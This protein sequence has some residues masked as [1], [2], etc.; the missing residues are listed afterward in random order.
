MGI[1]KIED[2]IDLREA[3]KKKAAELKMKDMQARASV[4]SFT[5]DRLRDVAKKHGILLALT[6]ELR[7]EVKELQK[8]YNIPSS[9]IITEQITEHNVL[10]KFSKIDHQKL[11]MLAYQRVLMSKEETGG[12]IPLSE[13]FELVNTGIL[14]GNIEVKDVEKALK[15][16]KKTKVIEDLTQLESGAIIAKFFP[17]QYTGDESKVVELA[18]EKGVLILEDICINLDWSQDR[19][20]RALESLEKSGIAKFRESILTGKQWYFPS[21]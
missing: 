21:F 14:N 8:V 2:E 5:K 13:V 18:K 17:I 6:P 4:E 12:I 1:R 9:K 15:L 19:A 11:G 7:Q 10:K 3:M 20:L 16:L